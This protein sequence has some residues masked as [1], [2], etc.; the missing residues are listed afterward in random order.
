MAPSVSVSSPPRSPDEPRRALLVSEV[1]RALRVT[2]D[3]VRRWVQGGLLPAERLGP[4]RRIL[5]DPNDLGRLFANA[6]LE[7]TTPD[8]DRSGSAQR[9]PGEIAS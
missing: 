7:P 4:G 6:T 1:A 2:P 9:D 3:T 5:I 8:E